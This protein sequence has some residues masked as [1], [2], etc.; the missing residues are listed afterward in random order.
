[1]QRVP[2]LARGLATKIEEA[3]GRNRKFQKAFSSFFELCQLSL[4][5]NIRREAVDEML[6]QHLLTERLFR[7]IFD[8]AEFTR[9]NVIAIEVER[10][11]EALVSAS[12]SRT[13]YLTSLDSFYVAIETAARTISDFS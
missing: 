12:F 3:H 9:R 6:V 2:E 13:A 11:I 7:T 10:V 8:N 1:E 4:N 5:P